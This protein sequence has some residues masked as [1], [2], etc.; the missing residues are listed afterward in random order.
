MIESMDNE[1]PKGYGAGRVG[2]IEVATVE[3]VG[4]GVE[5]KKVRKGR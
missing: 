5:E 2:G 1:L 4:A 3:I